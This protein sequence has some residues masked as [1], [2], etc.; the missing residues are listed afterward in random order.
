MLPLL[1]L[2]LQGPLTGTLLP[3]ITVCCRQLTQLQLQ[4]SD[5]RWR[6][7][8]ELS[9][10]TSLRELNI[11][12]GLLCDVPDDTLSMFSSFGQLTKLD[13]ASLGRKVSPYL[14]HTLATSPLHVVS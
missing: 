6:L 11:K 12:G 14:S 1:E 8:S 3:T 13:A 5:P 4:P 2:Q 10:L 7:P 9:Q